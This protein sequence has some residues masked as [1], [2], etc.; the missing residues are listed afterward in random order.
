M[1]SI[2]V[3]TYIGTDKPSII[4]LMKYRDKIAP[5][6][7]HLGVQLLQLQKYIDKLYVIKEN[8][9]NKVEKC[10]DEMFEYWLSV[11]V[12]ANW[13]KLIDALEHIQQNATAAIIRQDILIGKIIRYTYM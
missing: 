8:N 13:N 10:C 5:H 1:M 12:Q 4:L 2:F 11:D 9:S 3:H 7:Y 6:W